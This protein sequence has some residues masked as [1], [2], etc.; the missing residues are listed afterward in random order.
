MNMN[1]NVTSG[2]NT[3]KAPKI[4][5]T[6]ATGKTGKRIAH[7]LEQQGGSVRHGSRNGNPAFDWNDDSTWAPALRNIESVYLSYFPD[8][9][10]PQA[11]AAIQKFCAMAKTEGVEHLVLLSGRGEPAAQACEEIVQ[12][13]G[14]AWTIVRASWFNQNFSEGAFAEMVASGVIALPVDNVLEPFIDVDD[15]ADV[16]VAALRATRHRYQLY[17]VTGPRLLSFSEIAKELSLA[18]GKEIRFVPI[19]T[20]VFLQ[21]MRR[22]GVPAETL[23]LLVF[24]FKEVLD[25]R[26]A[27]TSKGVEEA[28]G[29]PARDFS[30]YA[31]T[32]TQ[33]ET[34]K[35][36]EISA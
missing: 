27:Y 23:E 2:T 17:E 11:P 4:L 12:A 6:G 21:E 31:N 1:A 20:K 33:T 15:I 16:A 7:K 10:V 3:I 34:H 8:L 13:S 28:L 35:Q 25:G 5:I 14:L 22:K 32:L 19:S 29:R 9:A 18:L 26:N 24:L 36:E 30:T